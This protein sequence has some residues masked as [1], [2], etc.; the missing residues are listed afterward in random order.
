[1]SLLNPT[2]F[3]SSLFPSQ[4]INPQLTTDSLVSNEFP[5]AI[6]AC[7]ATPIVVSEID[8]TCNCCTSSSLSALNIQRL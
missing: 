3:G 7:Y 2:K 8:Q 6:T 1:M 4:K 5:I